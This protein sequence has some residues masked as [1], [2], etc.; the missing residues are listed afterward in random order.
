M[1]LAWNVGDR[2]VGLGAGR[3][4]HWEEKAPRTQPIQSSLQCPAVPVPSSG[5]LLL[6]LSLRSP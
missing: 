5:V 3:K 4:L 2:L 1:R 6:L